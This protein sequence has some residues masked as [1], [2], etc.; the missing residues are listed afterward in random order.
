MHVIN[1]RQHDHG[2]WKITVRG[3][4]LIPIRKNEIYFRDRYV[5]RLNPNLERGLL[6]D[7]LRFLYLYMF[8]FIF[9]L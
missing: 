6:R 8:P 2:N 7:I 9:P 5:T 4:V 3:I 1:G